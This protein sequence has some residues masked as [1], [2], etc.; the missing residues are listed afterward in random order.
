[1]SKAAEE[2]GQLA[3][4]LVEEQRE[5]EARLAAILAKLAPAKSRGIN[6]VPR[7]H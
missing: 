2:L 6:V 3:H 1:M 7:Y 4:A 5:E